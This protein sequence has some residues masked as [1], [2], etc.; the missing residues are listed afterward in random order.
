MEDHTGRI[1]VALFDDGW[2]LYSELLV[3]DEI[4]VVE[5]RVAT[6]TFSGG[7]RMNAQKIMPLSEAKSRFAKGIQ[8]SLRGPDEE[9]CSSLQ[10]TFV[11]Y[12]DGSAVVWLNYSNA[13][14]RARLKLGEEWNVKACEELV[15]ALGELEMVSDA[16]LV[17]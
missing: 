6:D 15:A 16:R 11:P 7:F 17:Y 1:E 14:A 10:S 2:T 9:I 8:I 13:R 4:I 3:K 5:G 12:Q